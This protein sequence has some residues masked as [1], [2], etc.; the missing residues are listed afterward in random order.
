MVAVIIGVV[1]LLG[2]FFIKDGEKEKDAEE[3][4]LLGQQVE[5]LSIKGL[6]T[7]NDKKIRRA[8]E[9]LLK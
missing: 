9:F 8:C 3:E 4:P 6:L 7:T 1:Q 2:S 5:P